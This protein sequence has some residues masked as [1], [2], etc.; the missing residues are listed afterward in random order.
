MNERY[1][2]EGENIIIGGDF[3]IPLDS[4]AG[5][6]FNKSV[7]HRTALNDLLYCFDLCDIWRLNNTNKHMFIWFNRKNKICCMLDC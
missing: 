6:D 2:I 5:S 3:N 4:E 7:R 1:I